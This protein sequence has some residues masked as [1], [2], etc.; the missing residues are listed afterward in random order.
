MKV[1]RE[2]I[3]N[4]AINFLKFQVKDSADGTGQIDAAKLSVGIY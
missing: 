3:L 1:V 4:G 2:F